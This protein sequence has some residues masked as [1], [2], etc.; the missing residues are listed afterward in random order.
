MYPRSC[1][2]NAV[3]SFGGFCLHAVYELLFQQ[4]NIWHTVFMNTK[5]VTSAPSYKSTIAWGNDPFAKCTLHVVLAL[6]FLVVIC[7]CEL[8][9]VGSVVPVNYFPLNRTML[10]FFTGSDES[11]SESHQLTSCSAMLQDAEIIFS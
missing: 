11:V 2:V 5:T 8:C 6:L 9:S 3:M 10:F 7:V 1:L 4:Q